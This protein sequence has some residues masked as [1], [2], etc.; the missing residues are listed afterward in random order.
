MH[1]ETAINSVYNQAHGM[2]GSIISSDIQYHAN[3]VTWITQSTRG[4]DSPNDGPPLP[5]TQPFLLAK[6]Y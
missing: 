4:E 5:S 3:A 2:F 6:K 1:R